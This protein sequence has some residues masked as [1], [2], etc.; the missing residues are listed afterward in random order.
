M[1][2]VSPARLLSGL[3]D[4]TAARTPSMPASSCATVAARSVRTSTSI[5]EITPLGTPPVSSRTSASCAGPLPASESEDAW[6]TLAPKKAPTSTP[7]IASA[8]IAAIQR[9]RTTNLAHLV[10]ARLALL[11]RRI[12]G[13][14]MRGPM[15]PRIAGVRLRVASTLASGISAPPKPMLRMNG[16]GSTT[17]ASRPIAT[18]M[19][20]KSTAWP[21]VCIATTTASRLSRP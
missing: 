17:N 16:T 18:V 13:Q 20:L 3:F 2:T 14:S 10:Q 12:R 9:R 11:S 6:P 1:T 21:A 7:S 4:T 5:G 15:P 8:P 19:P